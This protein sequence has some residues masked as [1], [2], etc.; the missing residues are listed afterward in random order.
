MS[1]VIFTKEQIDEL[2]SNPN[3]AK[4]SDKAITYS[5][6]FKI[7][8]VQLYNEGLQPKEIFRQAGFNINVIGRR[9]PQWLMHSWNKL[10]RLKGEKG[11]KTESRGGGGG[12][13]KLKTKY[14]S[15]REKIKWMEAEIAY[16]KAE[17]DFLA[18]LRA[19]RAE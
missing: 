5:K 4:C 2:L 13:G 17:N 6:E 3:V 12:R 8:A 11:L 10:F 18:K 16:L 1:N 9:K 7:K 14:L 15:D 19:K